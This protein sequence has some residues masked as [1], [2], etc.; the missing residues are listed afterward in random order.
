[1][2]SRAV[3]ASGGDAVFGQALH[4]Q[5]GDFDV[6]RLDAR[7]SPVSRIHSERMA[8]GRIGQS[9]ETARR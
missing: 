8:L 5:R 2:R 1:M 9:G 3:G 6:L 7:G 4:L